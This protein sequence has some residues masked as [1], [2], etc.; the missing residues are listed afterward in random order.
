MK[1]KR[2][3][4]A[5]A[6]ML[7]VVMTFTI[8]AAG[9]V[10]AYD[11]DVIG[12]EPQLTLV[13]SSL[14]DGVEHVEELPI[15]LFEIY[16]SLMDRGVLAAVVS[17]GVYLGW[18]FF[19]QEA[20]GYVAEGPNRGLRG[21]G[22][23]IYRD[24]LRITPAPIIDSTNFLD[25]AGTIS[26]EYIIVTVDRTTGVYISRTIA[27]TPI[28][29]TSAAGTGQGYFFEIP[30]TPPAATVQPS[31]TVLGGTTTIQYFADE[32]KVADLDG[33]GQFEFVIRWQNQNFDVIQSGTFA[34]VIYQAIRM[35]GTVM[36]EINMGINIRAG[37]HYQQP[38][39]YDFDGDG[40]AELMTMTAPGT[41]DAL[42]RTLNME[43]EFVIGGTYD[44]FRQ[45]DRIRW[46]RA[47]R[48]IRGNNPDGTAGGGAITPVVFDAATPEQRAAAAAEIEQGEF[49]QVMVEFFMDWNS[50][51]DVI[52]RS[53]WGNLD[54]RPWNHTT[55]AFGQTWLPGE[56][57]DV[58]P[59]VDI[60]WWVSPPQVML[61][62]YGS[63]HE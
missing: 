17:N 18:R 57:Q 6:L 40:R 22:F 32:I 42:G 25:P 26:S 44:D 3:M 50:H 63:N 43:G 19:P 7:S 5:I 21:T 20:T 35:D 10:M 33:D 46:N 54:N 23:V 28:Q 11:G 55:N 24:G 39:L 9:P 36:W 56:N 1:N 59:G 4:R 37:Q 16:G 45:W 47:E 58:L 41:R 61:G 13:P 31:N 27:Q 62:M 2:F 48:A 53:Y 29:A 49:F 15:S 38:M 60:G 14:P 8:I 52:G 30:L 34:P 12:A 51:P